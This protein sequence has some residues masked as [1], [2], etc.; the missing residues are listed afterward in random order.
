MEASL[1]RIRAISVWLLFLLGLAAVALGFVGSKIPGNPNSFELQLASVVGAALLGASLS[2]ITEQILGTDISDIRNYLLSKERIESA[3][4]HLGVID[5]GWHY[6]DLSLKNG[7][8]IWQY[9]SFSLFRGE[10][11][12]TICG[13][14]YQIG[15]S[16]NRRRY[17]IEAGIRGGALL[18]IIRASEGDEHDQIQIVPFIT[19]THLGPVA[20]VQIMETWDG[21]LCLSYVIY[22]R[23]KLTGDAD[24]SADDCVR[25]DKLLEDL[26]KKSGIVDLRKPI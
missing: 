5:G 21:T 16:G 25:L 9:I 26:I 22:S 20:G 7:Q 23:N 11:Y 17:S 14:W 1:R 12:N 19:R 10:L 24:L 18:A 13:H 6:Y 2:I 3:P 8:R 15:E 4:D